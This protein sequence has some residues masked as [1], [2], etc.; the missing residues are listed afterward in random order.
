MR[1]YRFNLAMNVKFM[2]NTASIAIF[3][4]IYYTDTWHEIS[5]YLLNFHN[6]AILVNISYD[7]PKRHE[8][9]RKIFEY[10]P[11]AIVIQSA[12]QGKDIGAKLALMDIY[13]KMELKTDYL[14]LLHDKKSPQALDGDAWR[15]KLFKIVQKESIPIILNRF[16]SKN[17]GMVAAID[18]IVNSTDQN[19]VIIN[20]YKEYI[21]PLLAAYRLNQKDETFVGGTMFWVRS[22]IF[23]VFFNE[24]SPL[25]IRTTLEKG[26]VTDNKEPRQTHAWER[27]LCWIVASKGL[28]ISGV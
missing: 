9:S 1:S 23:E 25:S 26:N 24:F 19:N 28:K 20:K 2:K 4:H 16:N 27:I 15:K 3:I 6:P 21:S 7:N 10:F 5:K 14:I 13:L 17:I 12:N 11:N 8:I 22:S 18:Q